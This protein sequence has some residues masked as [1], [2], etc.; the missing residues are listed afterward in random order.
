VRG[1]ARGAESFA[2][3]GAAAVLQFVWTRG[4]FFGMISG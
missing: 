4:A 2:A 3:G 1:G